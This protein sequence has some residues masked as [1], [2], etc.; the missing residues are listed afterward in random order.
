MEINENSC[1]RKEL[2]NEGQISEERTAISFV[3]KDSPPGFSFY[4]QVIRKVSPMTN[5]VRFVLA[6]LNNR[7]MIIVHYLEGE[8]RCVCVYVYLYC[9]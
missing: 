6:T 9:A 5:R 7:I 2:G 3:T 8:E 4:W 1:A